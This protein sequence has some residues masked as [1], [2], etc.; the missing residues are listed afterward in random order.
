MLGILSIVSFFLFWVF[1]AIAATAAI[2]S[3]NS[4][5]GSGLIASGFI[6]LCAFGFP[7]L[8]MILGIIGIAM[9]RSLTVVAAIGLAMNALLVGWFL[10]NTVQRHQ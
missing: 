4:R 5:N 10:I 9:K 1:I 2:S 7:I 6:G 8:G 3:I